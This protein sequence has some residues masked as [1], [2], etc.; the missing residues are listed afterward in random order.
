MA[1][2]R[3][4]TLIELLV[5]IAI[6]ALLISIL[7]P[8]LGQARRAGQR[9]ASLANLRSNATIFHNYALDNKDALINP[10]KYSIPPVCG[11]VWVPDNGTPLGSLGWVY[12]QS[13]TDIY[14]CHWLA[15]TFYAESDATARFKSNYAPNDRAL[16]NWLRSNNEANAQT[17]AQWIFPTSY[18]YPPVFWQMPARFAGTQRLMTDVTHY[19]IQRH[20]FGDITIPD[21]KVL[22]FE[23]KE[24]DNP[25]QPMWNDLKA[26]PLTAQTDG[27]AKQ[28]R[29]KDIV[30]RTDPTGNITPNMLAAPSGAF[31]YGDPMMTGQQYEYG[32]M[33]GFFWTFG[34]PAY[35]WFTRNG[36][37][38][39]DF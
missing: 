8:S 23:G 16:L 26:S 29:I 15:H 3:G 27:S 12:T 37:H 2:R 22:L 19:Y 9:T 4:F 10:F 39:R 6:I 38:G 21:H 32:S 5:V 25:L 31:D 34:D 36:I 11:W 35:F 20:K 33:Q 14:G 28:L 24:Y 13:H 1:Q 30:A 18:W 7:L 17:N